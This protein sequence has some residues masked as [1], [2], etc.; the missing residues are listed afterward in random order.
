MDKRMAI[1]KSSDTKMS[2]QINNKQFFICHDANDKH[3]CLK[4]K[5]MLEC[6]GYKVWLSEENAEASNFDAIESSKAVILCLNEKF[7]CLF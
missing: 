1:L 3:T 5:D 6:H 4:I 7:R 2:E